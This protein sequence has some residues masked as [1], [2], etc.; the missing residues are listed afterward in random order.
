M[1]LWR[2]EGEKETVSG[3]FFIK[4][5]DSTDGTAKRYGMA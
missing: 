5:M 3:W 2:G 1:G 4:R